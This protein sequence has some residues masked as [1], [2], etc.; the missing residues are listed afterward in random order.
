M[1]HWRWALIDG[2]VRGNAY[3]EQLPSGQKN[4][5]PVDDLLLAHLPRGSSAQAAK[6]L[7]EQMGMTP[8]EMKPG[9]SQQP[10]ALR[11]SKRLSESTL[12]SGLHELVVHITLDKD[13][14]QDVS[15]TVFYRSL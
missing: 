12:F 15:A 7:C 6:T 1:G 14:V 4:R 3:D 11:C 2:A 9:P 8:K 5:I 13:T 10:D